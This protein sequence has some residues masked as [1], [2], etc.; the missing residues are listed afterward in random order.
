MLFQLSLGEA[1]NGF[2]AAMSCIL[3]SRV[4]LNVRHALRE[5]SIE[6]IES[7]VDDWGSTE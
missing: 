5:R 2:A 7:D 6:T 1:P 3:S 4:V